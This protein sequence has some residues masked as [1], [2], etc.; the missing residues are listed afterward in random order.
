M[1]SKGEI[2]FMNNQLAAERATESAPL[3]ATVESAASMSTTVGISSG[4]HD[5]FTDQSFSALGLSQPDSAFGGS[6][7]AEDCRSRIHQ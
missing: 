3:S 5:N 6:V 4:N 7:I 1:G 2:I